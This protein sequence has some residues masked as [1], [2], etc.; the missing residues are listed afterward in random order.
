LFF[1]SPQIYDLRERTLPASDFLADAI[2]GFQHVRGAIG[3]F[4]S[5][6]LRQDH[7]AVIV[8]HNP[9]ARTHG[10]SADLYRLVYFAMAVRIAG[11]AG[12]VPG[13][14]VE[15]QLSDIAGVANGSVYD[16]SGDSFAF[17][18]LRGQFAPYCRGLAARV[19][20]DHVAGLGGVNCFYRL[21]PV[22]GEGLNSYRR[23]ACEL[24]RSQRLDSFEAW[25]AMASV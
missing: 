14:D 24:A 18:A 11:V 19:D 16:E 21:C 8:S 3:H 1:P 4:D 15:L 7:H 2:L 22:A 5:L 20:N 12:Y 10:L 13:P 6:C 25:K 23:S 9:V 17:C